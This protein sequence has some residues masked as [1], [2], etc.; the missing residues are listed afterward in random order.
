MKIY[1]IYVPDLNTY[2]KYK[3]LE[4][5]QIEKFVNELNV[6]TE[7]DRRRKILQHVIF[8]LKT[9]VSAALGLMTR[10]DAERCIEALYTR[11]RNAKSRSRYRL[12]D[13]NCLHQY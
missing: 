10:P 3:V 2:V 5:E 13:S 12:L 4:P 11:M 6:K 9:E 8:N 1:Q 7:K